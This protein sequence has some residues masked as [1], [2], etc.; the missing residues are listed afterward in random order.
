[1]VREALLVLVGGIL[2]GLVA[3]LLSPRGLNLRR[4]YFEKAAPVQRG[5]Q[6]AGTGIPLTRSVQTNASP[7]TA[8][9]AGRTLDGFQVIAAEEVFRL[10]GD[11][12]YAQRLVILIDARDDRHYQ[13]AH[14]P[15][16][17]QFDRYYPEKYLPAVLPSALNAEQVIVYC[18][19]GRCE[20]S[21]LAAN[22]LKEAGVPAERIY[23]FA[24]GITEWQSKQWPV[25]QGSGTAQQLPQ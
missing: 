25:E 17:L 14:I 1:M 15:G 12:R 4:D 5:T 7:D 20:D 24:G 2:L 16:A 13:Q 19:G 10:I 22:A 9:A 21:E 8:A 23:I 3:N 6:A 11:P 18:N